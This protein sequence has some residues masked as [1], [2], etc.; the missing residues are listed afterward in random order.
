MRVMLFMA[1]NDDEGL[2]V[3]KKIVFRLRF[4]LNLSPFFARIL[5]QLS[6]HVYAG[7]PSS[8]F[9]MAEAVQ[10]KRTHETYA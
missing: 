5:E 7:L 10:G 4:S 8:C 1:Q 2:V 9:K 3:A 6:Q